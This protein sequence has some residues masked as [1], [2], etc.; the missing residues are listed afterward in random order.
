M[1][2]YT[3]LEAS[4][5]LG[6]SKEAVYN[7][8]RRGSLQSVSGENG[9]KMIILDDIAP[10]SAKRPAIKKEVQKTDTSIVELLKGQIEE[11]NRLIS[12]LQNR[13]EHLICERENSQIETNVLLE[14]I[15]KTYD[16]KINSLFAYIKSTPALQH[17][18]E[19]IDVSIDVE[20]EELT[21]YEKELVSE[22]GW[23]NLYI[24]MQQKKYSPKK[25]K[26]LT[27]K[28]GKCDSAFVK[29]LNGELFIKKGKKIKDLIGGK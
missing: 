2:R 4:K 9:A 16:D 3:V 12:S 18:D 8:V 5:I 29:K 7:R 1:N 25:Q 27:H 28:L 26:R 23:V 22:D 15:Y 19:C 13:V 10:K 20:F 21:P 17:K 24:F 11:Q 6:I 14:K